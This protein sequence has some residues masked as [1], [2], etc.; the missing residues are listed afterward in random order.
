[1]R[2]VRDEDEAVL[3]REPELGSDPSEK[4]G[5]HAVAGKLVR[6]DQ[7]SQPHRTRLLGELATEAFL[8]SRPCPEEA[9]EARERECQHRTALAGSGRERAGGDR[10]EQRSEILRGPG[11]DGRAATSQLV[12]NREQGALAALFALDVLGD[13]PE[14]LNPLDLD[15]VP[16]LDRDVE[17]LAC[18]ADPTTGSP[19]RPKER[20]DL[21]GD[22]PGLGPGLDVR[23]GRDLDQ[24]NAQ[25]VEAIDDLALPLA[26]LSCGVLLEADRKDL[27]AFP[28]YLDRPVHGDQ[29]G[30]LEPRGVR[31][32]DDDLPH[33]LDLV[34]GPCVEEQRQGECDVQRVL[35]EGPGRLL[36]HLHEA[37]DGPG[38]VA[39]GE[40]PGRFE[41][42]GR[43]DPAVLA[44]GRSEPADERAPGLVRQLRGTAAEQLAGEELLVDLEP[45]LH[46]SPSARCRRRNSP[47]RSWVRSA[48]TRAGS[49][50]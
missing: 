7:P 47:A 43:V 16:P 17:V 35:R 5:R 49:V 26:D 33:H 44:A 29:G 34:D 48:L 30:P 31:P 19:G 41:G 23:S 13:L 22:L 20:P 28:A 6:V 10:F 15:A 36:V 46:A 14:L 25:P 21:L 4:F 11:R 12:P 18:G 1:M 32:V 42:G 27:V 9:S 38:L 45:D 2:G 8:G 50:A 3:L 24:R 40:S 39:E 37:I